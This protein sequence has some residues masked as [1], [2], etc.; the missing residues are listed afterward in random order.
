MWR[1]SQIPFRSL[2]LI[3]LAASGHCPP[4]ESYLL[5][6][7]H[8]SQRQPTYNS[9]A[10]LGELGSAFHLDWRRLY[11]TVQLWSFRRS[12]KAFVPIA[13]WLNFPLCPVLLPP[14]VLLFPRCLPNQ[15]SAANLQLRICFS[16]QSTHE[17][18]CLIFKNTLHLESF[19]F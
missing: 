19:F 7:M 14:L 10:M 15:P 16:W 13:S 4:E 5:L 2:A 17:S 12:P 11:G 1:A 8:S 9:W 18:Q 3:P 6:F